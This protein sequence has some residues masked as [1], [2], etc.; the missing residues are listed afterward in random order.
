METRRA[1]AQHTR[2]VVSDWI[3]SRSREVAQIQ[4][5]DGGPV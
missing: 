3:L 4:H 2:Q 5:Q 1:H